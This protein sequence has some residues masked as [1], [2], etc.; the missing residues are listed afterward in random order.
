MT[1]PA[2]L[3]P[4]AGKVTTRVGAHRT[5]LATVRDPGAAGAVVES[6]ATGGAPIHRSWRRIHAVNA[7]LARGL[8][9]AV[10]GGWRD[11]KRAGEP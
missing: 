4:S 7:P 5:R 1:T 10:P 6:K 3:C 9:Q 8:R 2:R 11:R